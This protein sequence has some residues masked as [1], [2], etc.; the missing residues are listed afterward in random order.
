[1]EGKGPL[2]TAEWWLGANG[3]P[4]TVPIEGEDDRCE[5]WALQRVCIANGRSPSEINNNHTNH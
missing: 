4:F 1:M 5:F 2:N 3:L